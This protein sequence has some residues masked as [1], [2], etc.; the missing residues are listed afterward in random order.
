MSFFFLLS[1]ISNFL[2]NVKN[3][4]QLTEEENENNN[5]SS[6][7]NLINDISNENSSQSLN[8]ILLQYKEIKYISNLTGIQPKYMLYFISSI[9]IIIIINFFSKAFTLFVGVIY[10][11]RCSIKELRARNKEGIQKWLEYWVVFFLFFNI[12]TLLGNILKKIPMYLFYKV[13]FLLVLFLPWYNG[14]HYIYNSILREW[15]LYYEKTL[16]RF[17]LRLKKRISKQLYTE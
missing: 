5:E 2:I 9:F 8:E 13:V 10:P 7:E 15:F 6:A 4:T 17:S 16:Y 14:V 12:E 3:S 11:V 1:F